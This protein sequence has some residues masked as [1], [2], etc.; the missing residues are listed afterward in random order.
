MRD[1][2]KAIARLSTF[3][4]TQAALLSV[5]GII[6]A[7]VLTAEEFGVTRVVTNYVLILVM[8]GHFCIHDA[9]ASHVARESTDEGRS[10]YIYSAGALVLAIS[11]L[12]V[13]IAELALAFSLNMDPMVRRALSGSVIWIPAVAL[14]LVCSSVMQAVGSLRQLGI[15]LLLG[16]LVPL[17]IVPLG[18]IWGGIDGWVWGRGAAAIVLLVVSVR[19]TRQWAPILPAIIVMKRNA[20]TLFCF[21]RVQILSGALSMAIQAADLIALERL[22]GGMKDLATYGIA[23]LFAKSTVVF[24]NSI[25]RVYFVKIAREGPDMWQAILRLILAVTGVCI[26]LAAFCDVIVPVLLQKLYGEKY[27]GAHEILRVMLLG[28]LFSGLLSAI[29]T[30][31]VALKSPMSAFLISVLSSVGCVAALVLLIP[32]YGAI[33]A[34]WAM[35][36]TYMIGVL[37]GGVLLAR[38][39]WAPHRS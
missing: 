5:L 30:I 35:N 34:A 2:I 18:A 4:V 3:S 13:A 11:L 14:S 24:P 6:L 8:L 9:A 7:K 1:S 17:A 32:L 20:L 16:G 38:R 25:G 27:A 21:A 15:Y 39:R 36:L 19:I 23:A 12:V 28:V 31:N 37:T 33:G 10:F 26:G 22:G 29:S